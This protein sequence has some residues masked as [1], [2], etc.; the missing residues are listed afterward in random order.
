M[1]PLCTAAGQFDVCCICLCIRAVTCSRRMNTSEDSTMSVS[2][3]WSCSLFLLLSEIHS[4]LAGKITVSCNSPACLWAIYF[5]SSRLYV[6]LYME[7]KLL[8]GPYHWAVFALVET[9]QLVCCL[10]V[11]P[12]F[13]VSATE[14]KRVRNSSLFCVH[15]FNNL[16]FSY[17]RSRIQ[18]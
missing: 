4:M 14:L 16:A 3:R 13:I 17:G 18:C 10:A 15:N 11:Y 2:S 12:T 7:Y 9:T 8:G 1:S 5:Y 6:D